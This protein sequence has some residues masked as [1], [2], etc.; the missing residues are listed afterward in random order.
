MKLST[1]VIPLSV[2]LSSVAAI[3]QCLDDCLKEGPS[4]AKCGYGQ[5]TCYCS[6]NDF[7]NI[8]RECIGRRCSDKKDQDEALRLQKQFCGS[9]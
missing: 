4:T 8:M 5:V 3:P 7:Q 2:L 9:S 1:V 6:N